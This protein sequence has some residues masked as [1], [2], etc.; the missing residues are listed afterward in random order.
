MASTGTELSLDATFATLS[1]RRRRDVLRYLKGNPGES[2]VRTLTER[3]AAWE[4]DVDPSEVSYRQRKR[5]YTSLHQ[6]HLP[7]LAD[8]G[9]IEYE[10]H[11]GRVALTPA[12]AEL[13]VYLETVGKHELPWSEYYLGLGAV[14][15]AATVALALGVLPA[16]I[17]TGTTLSA[18]V[19]L[20]LFVSA[21]VHVVSSRRMR[22]EDD[23]SPR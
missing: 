2:S 22:L 5:V 7:K 3:I 18:V 8:G 23:T 6:T 10:P 1:N 4:N 16:G 15:L 9:F 11:R 20:V 19:G 12:A 21:L 17:I 14:S 13:D